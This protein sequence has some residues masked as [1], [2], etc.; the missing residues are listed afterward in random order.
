MCF[1]IKFEALYGIKANEQASQFM[2][3]YVAAHDK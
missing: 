2:I 3:N 1:C